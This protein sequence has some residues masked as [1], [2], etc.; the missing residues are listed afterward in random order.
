MLAAALVPLAPAVAL[1]EE[2]AAEA[3]VAAATAAA[4]GGGVGRV[5]VLRTTPNTGRNCCKKWAYCCG[6]WTISDTLSRMVWAASWAAEYCDL[7]GSDEG[8][9]HDRRAERSAA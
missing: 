7:V 1:E 6:S 4:L 8:D 3:A 2:A 5:P 9:E